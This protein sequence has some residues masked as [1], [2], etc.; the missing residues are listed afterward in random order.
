MRVCND[1][2]RNDG[3]RAHRGIRLSNTS[4]LRARSD[5][6]SRANWYR[7]ATSPAR[8]STRAYPDQGELR[9]CRMRTTTAAQW[10]SKER[11]GDC[12]HREKNPRPEDPCTKNPKRSV[13]MSAEKF[14]QPRV[15]DRDTKVQAGHKTAQVHGK[16]SRRSHKSKIR[17]VVAGGA[18]PPRGWAFRLC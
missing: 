5:P 4:A 17:D 1:V 16:I 2:R 10:R 3:P 9:P 6:K 13:W 18:P 14:P 15:A 8:S 12:R 7:A 11:T